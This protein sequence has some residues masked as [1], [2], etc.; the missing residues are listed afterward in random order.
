MVELARAIADPPRVLLLDEPAS[1]LDDAELAR[2][3]G[4]IKHV[5]TA[6]SCAVLLVEHDAEFVMSH[7]D[8]VI[9]LVRGAVLA[10]GAPA[11][12]RQDQSVRAAYLGERACLPAASSSADGQGE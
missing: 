11:D 2:L 7:C 1:G 10:D 9:V 8:R 5:R 4:I 3:A 12:I 6:S